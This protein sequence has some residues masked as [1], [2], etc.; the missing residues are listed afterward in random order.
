MDTELSRVSLPTSVRRTTWLSRFRTWAADPDHP[1]RTATLL[2]L[3]CLFIYHINGRNQSGCDTIPP[4]YTAWALVQRGSL[5][6][7]EYRELE[8]YVHGGLHIQE[9]PDGH[10]ISI[11][12]PG[13]AL[14][15]VPFVAPFAA[16]S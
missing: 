16:C 8:R 10:W 13:S 1:T 3:A 6:L 2:F 7:S 14:A 9:M 12:P 5:D 4:A 15:A 11:R